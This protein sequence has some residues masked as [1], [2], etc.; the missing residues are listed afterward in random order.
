MQPGPLAQPCLQ[1]WP[2]DTLDFSDSAAIRRMIGIGAGVQWIADTKK[3]MLA[4]NL[5][6]IG[7]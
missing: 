1:G 2:L 3:S 5:E 4:R 6:K 7:G